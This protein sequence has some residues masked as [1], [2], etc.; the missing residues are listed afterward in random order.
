[1]L[2]LSAAQNP[3]PDYIALA[4]L[5]FNPMAFVE[6]LKHMGV[7]MLVIFVVIGI[8][9]LATKLVNYLFSEDK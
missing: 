5:K 7:G 1:M 6:N 4:N 2:I 9:I 3:K 8:I